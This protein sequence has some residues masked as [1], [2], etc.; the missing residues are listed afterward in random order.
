MSF[1]SCSLG[2]LWCKRT[3]FTMI[4]RCHWLHYFMQFRQI[5]SVLCGRLYP[6]VSFESSGVENNLSLCDRNPIPEML[7]AYP[8]EWNGWTGYGF[9]NKSKS[10]PAWPIV[11]IRWVLHRTPTS[12]IRLQ[13]LQ[14]STSVQMMEFASAATTYF[15]FFSSLL[16]LPFP[17]P[18]STP[19]FFQQGGPVA[20]SW[21]INVYV[22]WSAG[23]KGVACDP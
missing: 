2:V 17:A 18:L 15:F 5:G 4:M 20:A 7:N 13:L 9:N 11:S 1:R 19:F 10:S 14:T 8:G 16:L 6:L 21:L 22:F 12:T 23:Q 3:V